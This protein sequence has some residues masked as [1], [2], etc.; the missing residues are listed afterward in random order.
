LPTIEAGKEGDYIPTSP[1]A[2][3]QR[4]GGGGGGGEVGDGSQRVIPSW[5]FS[6]YYKQG[7]LIAGNPVGDPRNTKGLQ[8]LRNGRVR[9]E[10]RRCQVKDH[11]N[12]RE[13]T[14]KGT[15]PR[16]SSEPS[17]TVGKPL[18][19]CNGTGKNISSQPYRSFQIST[20]CED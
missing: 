2:N 6:C 14:E 13:K 8:I 9:H 20:R 11:G 18:G 17:R 12:I 10:K 19:H 7:T 5:A 15:P 4:G 3:T 1:I 16:S